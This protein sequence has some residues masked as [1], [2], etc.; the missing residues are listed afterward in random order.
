MGQVDEADKASLQ[1]INLAKFSEPDRVEQLY[2]L[3]ANYKLILQ[4]SGPILRGE[5]PGRQGELGPAGTAGP[6]D[7]PQLSV[8]RGGGHP[9]HEP[10]TGATASSRRTVCTSRPT[11]NT[12]AVLPFMNDSASSR[13]PWTSSSCSSR[14]TRRATRST[15]RPL[16]GRD[17]EGI[18]QRRRSGPAVLRTGPQVGSE[19]SA[20]RLA[21]AA[22]VYDFRRH[23]RARA[24]AVSTGPEGRAG[25]GSDEH[26]LRRHPVPCQLLE[27][28]N[29]G[30]PGG[31]DADA[32]AAGGVV[33]AEIIS[34]RGLES[35][36]NRDRVRTIPF[37]G[38]SAVVPYATF[39]KTIGL[40]F[41]PDRRRRVPP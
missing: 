33:G 37:D 16:R 36:P 13:T 23:D 20:P 39:G 41:D 5:R 18:L 17:L 22:V 30:R 21:Q 31:P 27:E 10:G 3:R 26:Q 38:M 7:G 29:E 24:M 32:A 9:G 12:R 19:Y 15:T 28:A 4:S 11:R 6:E 8:P 14:A 34:S 1:S 25:Y 35:I 40:G 2:Q